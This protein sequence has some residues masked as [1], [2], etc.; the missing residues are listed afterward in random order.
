MLKLGEAALTFPQEPD[1]IRRP[2]TRKQMHAL[3][4][5]TVGR[6]RRHLALASLD[7]HVTYQMVTRFFVIRESSSA[8]LHLCM[9][10]KQAQTDG[11]NYLSLKW[12]RARFDQKLPRGKLQT[13]LQR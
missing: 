10:E 4:E 12:H 1:H 3:T 5:R 2:R 9:H 13:L 6:G 8:L 11:A 7:D